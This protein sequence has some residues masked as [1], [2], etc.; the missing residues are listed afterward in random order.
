MF[1]PMSKSISQFDAN[2]NKRSLTS[3]TDDTAMICFMVFFIFIFPFLFKTK[4]KLF[5]YSFSNFSLLFVGLPN[6]DL[7]KKIAN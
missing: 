3:L 7:G 5:L 4:T 6:F 1:G 2:L